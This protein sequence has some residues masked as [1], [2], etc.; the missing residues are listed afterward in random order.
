M[1][2]LVFYN[3]FVNL[4]DVVV[5]L[6]VVIPFSCCQVLF[7]NLLFSIYLLRILL[8]KTVLLLIAVVVAVGSSPAIPVVVVVW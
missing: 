6:D 5:F 3:N 2:L 1:L 4:D 7:C 8:T